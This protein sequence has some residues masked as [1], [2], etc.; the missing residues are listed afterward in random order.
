MQATFYWD[1]NKTKANE[2]TK[3]N[4]KEA[5]Q[6]EL[7]SQKTNYSQASLSG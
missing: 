7:Q 1:Y 2:H 5:L 3:N 6:G 4:E